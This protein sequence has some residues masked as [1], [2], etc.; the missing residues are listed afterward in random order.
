MPISARFTHHPVLIVSANRRVT[1]HLRSL[2]QSAGF[3]RFSE[4][5]DIKQAT[6]ALDTQRFTLAI[7]D[8]EANPNP[9]IAAMASLRH[10]RSSPNRQCPSLLI[11]SALRQESLISAR[12]AGFDEILAKPF[13]LEGLEQRLTAIAN[14]RR[15][16]VNA[17]SFT[18]PDR[19]RRARGS[20]DD[21]RF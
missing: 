10:R 16:F 17:G 21:R 5:T 4:V 2:L 1:S 18:G 20:Q 12:D 6:H 11:A 13:S 8:S 19:R 14:H 15:A 3:M 7:F 9:E